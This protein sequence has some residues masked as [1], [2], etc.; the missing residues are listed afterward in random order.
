[1]AGAAIELDWEG[2]EEIMAALTR[3]GQAELLTLA[4]FAGEEQMNVTREAFKNRTDPVTNE[5]WDKKADE[6]PATL[7]DTGSLFRYMAY[8]AFPDGSV[9]QGNSKVYAAPHQYGWPEKNIPM[10]RYMGTND[11]II[12]DMM[13]QPEIKELLA[14]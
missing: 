5:K 1:M 12:R 4:E 3:L 11:G 14:A 10:R 8:E 7:F 6:T 13:E 9:I 2:Y